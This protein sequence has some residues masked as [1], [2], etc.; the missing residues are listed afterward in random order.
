MILLLWFLRVP[1]ALL[2]AG[3]AGTCCLRALALVLPSA[4]SHVPPETQRS[5]CSLRRLPL[6]AFS[7]GISPPRLAVSCNAHLVRVPRLFL[8]LHGQERKFYE[9]RLFWS[10]L[11]TLALQPWGLARTCPT[12]ILME[13]TAA[14]S[15]AKLQPQV[16]GVFHRILLRKDSYCP[17]SSAVF[18]LYRKTQETSGSP[19][20]PFRNH[21]PG[22]DGCKPKCRQALGS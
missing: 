18:L 1:A 7:N 17:D 11:L 10:A 5:C 3:K 6:T 13:G 16:Q 12:L 2:C 20:P 21:L 4:E 15:G 14:E 19:P 8:R 9:A 22:H